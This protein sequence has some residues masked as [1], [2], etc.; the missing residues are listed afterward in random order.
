MVNSVVQTW[1]NVLSVSV[2]Q[3]T[4]VFNFGIKHSR[5]MTSEGW[6][7]NSVVIFKRR[8]WLSRN[9]RVFRARC[10]NQRRDDVIKPHIHGR[11]PYLGR[12]HWMRDFTTMEDPSC[13][14]AGDRNYPWYVDWKR[15]GNFTSISTAISFEIGWKSIV[16]VNFVKQI[17]FFFCLSN[18]FWKEAFYY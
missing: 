14:T 10:G 13:I 15:C 4:K 12:V 6:T 9:S 2:T 11:V 7:S 8:S 17:F 3:T 16:I 5:E 1:P 18:R